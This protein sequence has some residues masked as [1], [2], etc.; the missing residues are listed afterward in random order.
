V[1]LAVFLPN[2]VGDAVLATPALRALR[3]SLPG[4]RLLGVMRPVVAEVLAGTGWL[5][6][7]L[8]FDPYGSARE[9]RT[10]PVVRQLR[11]QRPQTVLLFTNSLRTGLMAWLSGARRRVGYCMHGRR[12]LLTDRL[13]PP[14]RHGRLLP[15]SV[16]DAYLN[17]TA[18]LGCPAASRRLELAT[19]PADEAA[20]DVVWQRFGLPPHGEVVLLNSSGAYGEAKLWP[21][22]YFAQLARRLGAECGRMVL[23]LCGPAEQARAAEI[24]ARA[25]HPRVV[26]LAEVQPSIG[27]SKA[28]VRRAGLLIT[29]D[30]GPRHFAAAFNIPVVSLFGP[31]HPAWSENYHPLDVHLQRQ[32]PCGPCQRRRCPL[33]HHRCLRELSVEEVFQAACA[34][35]ARQAGRGGVQA[36]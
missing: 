34:L 26:S 6:E 21:T 27:L 30:S 24:A 1:T 7:Q 32:V 14:R 11:A 10:W 8:L 4:E 9:N 36:A 22:E 31:T 17:L 3:R 20:A 33:V 35:L 2:W 18:R 25:A 29:T 16:L 28:C 5:D 13:E 19:L 23:V 12:W 15:S